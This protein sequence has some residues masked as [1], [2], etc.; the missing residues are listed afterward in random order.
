M[1]RTATPG[2]RR[3][4]SRTPPGKGNGGSGR[5][6]GVGAGVG[7][8]TNPGRGGAASTASGVTCAQDRFCGV[9]SDAPPASNVSGPAGGVSSRPIREIGAIRSRTSI[10]PIDP[11]RP[12][13]RTTG[14]RVR[15]T[16]R[17]T[18]LSAWS[19]S[20]ACAH[21]WAKLAPPVT[22]AARSSRARSGAS[23]N[24]PAS[25]GSGATCR[26]CRL[27]ATARPSAARPNTRPAAS[28][29]AAWSQAAATRVSCCCC[30]TRVPSAAATRCAGSVLSC[31]YQRRG[32]GRVQSRGRRIRLPV[33]RRRQQ[34]VARRL[35]VGGVEHVD[36]RRR[37]P[38]LHR[39]VRPPLDG[40]VQREQGTGEQHLHVVGAGDPQS[41]RR[42][43]HRAGA[44]AVLDGA[45]ADREGQGLEVARGAGREPPVVQDGQLDR[46]HA[47]RATPGRSLG[48]AGVVPQPGAPARLERGHDAG[49]VL[50]LLRQQAPGDQPG[51]AARRVGRE[52]VGEGRV[53]HRRVGRQLGV[54]PGPA[55]LEVGQLLLR[56]GRGADRQD[57]QRAARRRRQP[58]AR[59]LADH[60]EAQ[61]RSQPARRRRGR[62]EQPGQ[63]RLVQ[64]HEAR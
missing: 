62:G 63:G 22:G 32:R 39:R 48:V 20:C 9:G 16:R 25:G 5:G 56:A 51:Q 10:L 44:E 54:R 59:L 21:C 27:S 61:P 43:V 35:L 26:R 18:G 30:T 14:P 13:R 53:R 57:R 49:E 8:I 23:T 2:R 55:L 15:V 3:P 60:D 4:A 28:R 33:P 29:S 58:H 17:T 42:Q 64:L 12:T 52:R 37:E 34:R 46:R 1:G 24:R 47:R 38:S 36:E 41:R 50:G 11:V 40:S 45:P 19:G 31:S 6:P 7:P